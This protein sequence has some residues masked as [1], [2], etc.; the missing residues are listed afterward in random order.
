MKGKSIYFFYIFSTIFLG[1]IFL[2]HLGGSNSWAQAPPPPTICEDKCLP[3]INED[4]NTPTVVNALEKIII[5]FISFDCRMNSIKTKEAFHLY[6]GEDEINDLDEYLSFSDYVLDHILMGSILTFTPHSPF[7]EGI[8]YKVEIESTA[9]NNDGVQFD[10]DGD[11][12]AGEDP[13]DNWVM[14]F[15]IDANSPETGWSQVYDPENI[16]TENK[17][18]S[19]IVDNQDRLWVT[20]EE[21]DVCYFDG[22]DW[23]C[24]KPFWDSDYVDDIPCMTTDNEGCL[25]LGFNVLES[26]F[27]TPKLAK[28]VNNS[29]EVKDLDQIPSDESIRDIAVD[30]ENNIWIIASNDIYKYDGELHYCPPG[31]EDKPVST[32]ITSLVIDP[33]DNLWVRTVTSEIWKAEGGW[34]GD[35]YT[36]R[37]NY[38][39]NDINDMAV[40]S[41]GNIWIGTDNGLLKLDPSSQDPNWPK[42]TIDDGLPGDSINAL[43]I[44]PN[45]NLIWVGTSDG[46]GKFDIA[47]ESGI[48]YTDQTSGK[49]INH[50]VLNSRGEVWFNT[51]QG[52]QMLDKIPPY[53][54][55]N[56]SVPKNNTNINILQDIQIVFSEPMKRDL[57]ESAFTMVEVEDG[58]ED[59]E[60][61]GAFSWPNSKT[62]IFDPNAIIENHSYK[63]VID[64]NAID[65][66]GNS[67]NELYSVV[68]STGE[69]ELPYITNKSCSLT[70]LVFY[71][72]DDGVVVDPNSI[73]VR[74]D[75]IDVTGDEGFQIEGANNSYQVTY[76]PDN[77]FP[78][79]EEITVTI[80]VK[81]LNG[82]PLPDH[83][84]QITPQ[85]PGTEHSAESPI[86]LSG[87]GCFLDTL[88]NRTKKN[89]TKVWFQQLLEF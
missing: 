74:V 82:N 5:Y 38:Q 73:E 67:L 41:A 25:W 51:N 8:V 15:I 37:C 72:N 29:W 56:E 62:L 65:L 80:T 32:F 76:S 52:I 69:Q 20:S 89:R 1:L 79:N 71:V 2:I 58:Q 30:S 47:T 42:Y 49:A 43:S 81:D 86:D 75:N 55:K 22:N 59:L 21:G 27:L 11:G 40:D 64:T 45:N 31:G 66:L 35:E 53:V 88:Q 63:V 12:T 44:D 57:T 78:E 39:I 3:E 70:Q 33:D 84:F 23:N 4:P 50:L 9:E 36:A 10:G 68:F 54:L 24:E 60:I 13:E 18:S 83:E 61:E 6:A 87:S 28:L 7:E 34:W 16:F 17:V 26:N 85:E 77:L 46:L 14:K 19:M 48:A